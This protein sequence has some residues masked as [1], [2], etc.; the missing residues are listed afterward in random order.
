MSAYFRQWETVEGFQGE[1]IIQNDLRF[2]KIIWCLYGG[3]QLEECF[4][5]DFVSVWT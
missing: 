3:G 2:R 5:L 1:D 4:Y